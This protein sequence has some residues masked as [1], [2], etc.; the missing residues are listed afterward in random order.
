MSIVVKTL[1]E[2]AYEIIRERILANVM[3]PAKPI[4]Q[5]ALSQ[6]LGV[7]KIPLREALTRLE[8]DGLLIS[9]PNRGFIVRP[10]SLAEAE[11]V[12]QLRK[13]LE[14]EAAAQ[15]CKRATQ[16]DRQKVEEI[17]KRLQSMA[18][19]IS[20]QAV[21]VNREFHLA[22]TAPANRKITQELLTKVHLLSERYVR[23]HLDPPDREADAFREHQEIFDAWMNRESKKVKTLLKEHTLSTLEDL[24][25]ELFE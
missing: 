3:F 21:T 9:H 4:R 20:P 15:G 14:P 16:Q 13:T 24:R 5:D 10:I 22:L 11:D 6:D 18:Y 2:Q 17:F 1:S 8:Q 19:E 7:S 25:G 12:F 23:R